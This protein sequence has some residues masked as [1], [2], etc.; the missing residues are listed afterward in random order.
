MSVCDDN[1]SL[2]PPLVAVYLSHT[3]DFALFVCV[4]EYEINMF[5]YEQ[6]PLMLLRS[7][8]SGFHIPNQIHSPVF[9]N[10]QLRDTA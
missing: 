9:G 6:L 3:C 8:W 7:L 5:M 1:S 2:N 4:I 10:M